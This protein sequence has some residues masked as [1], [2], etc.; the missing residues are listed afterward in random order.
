MRERPSRPSRHALQQRGSA[1][2]LLSRFRA[3]PAEVFLWLRASCLSGRG[4][5]RGDPI[6]R[7]LPLC[8]PL[9]TF[10][11]RGKSPVGDTFFLPPAGGKNSPPPRQRRKKSPDP[12]N[13][14]GR[15]ITASFFFSLP[16]VA[17]QTRIEPAPYMQVGRLQSVSTLPTSAHGHAHGSGGLHS[18][19]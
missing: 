15:G 12:G 19:A 5:I 11:A 4:Y 13:K 18:A 9:V 10:S 2:G 3:L 16:A 6:V 14:K 7:G 17:V 8:A 1:D